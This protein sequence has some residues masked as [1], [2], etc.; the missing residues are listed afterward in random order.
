MSYLK[1]MGQ[2]IMAKRNPEDFLL[3]HREHYKKKL[4]VQMLRSGLF[5]KK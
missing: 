5:E 2:H 3:N 4:A 1:Y